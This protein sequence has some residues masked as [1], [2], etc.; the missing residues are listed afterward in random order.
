M[1]VE[2]IISELKQSRER[3]QMTA[4]AQGNVVPLRML[5]SPLRYSLGHQS[6]HDSSSNARCLQ[7]G[8]PL[9]P[10]HVK[11]VTL[12]CDRS[13]SQFTAFQTVK[14]CLGEYLSSSAVLPVSSGALYVRSDS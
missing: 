13:S 4:E 7:D 10:D 8:V 9:A 1:D 11:T 5:V 6:I 2:Q 12:A 3:L 14:D